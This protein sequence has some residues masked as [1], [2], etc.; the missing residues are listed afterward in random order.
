MH[1]TVYLIQPTARRPSAIW[2]TFRTAASWKTS[3]TQEPSRRIRSSACISKQESI[4]C[5]APDP[6]PDE[7]PASDCLRCPCQHKPGSKV[8]P[9]NEA[10]KCDWHIPDNK[11]W[12]IHNRV[13]AL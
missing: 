1:I 10:P 6:K 12:G 5:E 11:F 2:T 4:C 7:A 3:R 9:R 8:D 13:F